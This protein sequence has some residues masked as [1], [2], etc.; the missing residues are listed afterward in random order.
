MSELHVKHEA[1]PQS[2]G[3]EH[4]QNP[5]RKVSIEQLRAAFQCQADGGEKQ[6]LARAPEVPTVPIR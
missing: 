4:F 1:E 5:P 6:L 3:R 2:H